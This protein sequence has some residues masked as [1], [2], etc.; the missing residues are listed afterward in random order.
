MRRKCREC[1]L[2]QRY[3]RKPLG[4]DPGMHHG[5]CVTSRTCRDACWDHLP[6]VTGK[7]F[8]AFHMRTRNFTYLARGPW[9]KRH[10]KVSVRQTWKLG[11]IDNG[12]LST[13]L[14]L[15]TLPIQN[16]QVQ[17][18]RHIQWDSHVLAVS[19]LWYIW[20]VQIEYCVLNIQ[21]H[22]RYCVYLCNISP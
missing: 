6:A 3:Q 22:T 10:G 17:T 12:N 13:Y 14:E 18:H 15:L 21:Y 20:M 16:K 19:L 4:N 5:T 11:S 8:P 7:T 9:H 2:P 1:F